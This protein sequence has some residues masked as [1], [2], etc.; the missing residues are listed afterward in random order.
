MNLQALSARVRTKNGVAV[1]E[2]AGDVDGSAESALRAG[3]QEAAA[4][5]TSTVLLDFGAVGYINST[6]IALIVGVLAEARRD[7]TK[8][9]ACG[10]SGHY[11]EIFQVTRLSDF[12]PIYADE[13][14]ALAGA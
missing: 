12:M 1:V 14:E 13:H 5:G 4:T 8:V 10:L 2:L 11:R 7:K 6:G 9:L 3:Y